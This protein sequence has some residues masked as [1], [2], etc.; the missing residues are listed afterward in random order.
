MHGWAYLLR[1]GSKLSQ[2]IAWKHIVVTLSLYQTEEIRGL[3]LGKEIQSFQ[4]LKDKYGLTMTF[5]DTCKWEI[6]YNKQ[7]ERR[8]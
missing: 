8:I 2:R 7:E 5:I 6:I 3:K 4:E 1:S